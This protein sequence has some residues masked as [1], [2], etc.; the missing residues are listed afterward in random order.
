MLNN[1][2]FHI[3]YNFRDHKMAKV[4][5]SLFFLLIVFGAQSNAKPTIS[6][7]EKNICDL[8]GL[9]PAAPWPTTVLARLNSEGFLTQNK[10]TQLK[11]YRLLC[12]TDSIYVMDQVLGY[13]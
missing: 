1:F 4:Y 10:A 8:I 5:L 13:F 11:K 9:H 12:I 6:N 7:L 2:C 3:Q